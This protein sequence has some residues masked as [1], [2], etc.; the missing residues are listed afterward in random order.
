VTAYS[1]LAARN[2]P[3]YGRVKMHQRNKD[4]CHLCFFFQPGSAKVCLFFHGFTASW[5]FVPDERSLRR[6]T[7]LIPLLPGMVRQVECWLPS[8]L[9]E[10]SADISTVWFQWLQKAQALGKWLWEAIWWQ[11]TGCLASARMP[12]TNWPDSG[13]CPVFGWQQ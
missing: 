4:D 2:S 5:Q 9:P 3:T 7:I 6:A 1:T 10:K 8:S 12:S 13:V 11:Y